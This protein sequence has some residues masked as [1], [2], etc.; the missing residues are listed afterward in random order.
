MSLS[1]GA[2]FHN[3]LF[4]EGEACMLK[5]ASLQD[6]LYG[7]AGNWATIVLILNPVGFIYCYDVFQWIKVPTMKHCYPPANSLQIIS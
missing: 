5:K 3:W 7:L 4:P 1:M 2:W 6:V